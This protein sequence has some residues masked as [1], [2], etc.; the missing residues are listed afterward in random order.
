MNDL[1]EEM[2]LLKEVSNPKNWHLNYTQVSK[3]TGIPVSTIYD[4]LNR[5][6]KRVV[7]NYRGRMRF[8][9]K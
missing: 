4:Y 6:E 1:K 2:K 8:R 5:N 3:K 7:K 9:K